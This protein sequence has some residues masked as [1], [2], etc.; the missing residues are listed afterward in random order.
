ME[1]P[2]KQPPPNRIREPVAGYKDVCKVSWSC[3]L[4]SEALSCPELVAVIEGQADRS[5]TQ[6]SS[7]PF[8]PFIIYL[9]H[10]PHP[11]LVHRRWGRHAGP[12]APVET[13]PANSS[14]ISN[15]E[16]AILMLLPGEVVLKVLDVFSLLGWRPFDLMGCIIP[17]RVAHG[18]LRFLLL[19]A[20]FVL[21][22]KIN[23]LQ[24]LVEISFSSRKVVSESGSSC[25][26]MVEPCLACSV[27]VRGFLPKFNPLWCL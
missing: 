26:D 9:K 16:Y 14:A 12:P 13:P 17:F 11:F 2:T 15:I 1:V 21:C 27:V 20:G 5:E 4:Q 8:Q 18:G 19:M 24:T 6:N 3:W 7:L 23:P 22:A 10:F 25:S